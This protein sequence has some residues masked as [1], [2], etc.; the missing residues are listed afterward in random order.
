MVFPDPDF[1]AFATAYL[2]NVSFFPRDDIPYEFSI[3]LDIRIISLPT[4]HQRLERASFVFFY[5]C[6]ISV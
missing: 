5:V 4:L 1:L 3:F 2:Y 6:A